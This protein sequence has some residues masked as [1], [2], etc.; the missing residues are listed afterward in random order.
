L[1]CG[2]PSAFSESQQ[3]PHRCDPIFLIYKSS[4]V[5]QYFSSFENLNTPT[6]RKGKYLPFQI[7]LNKKRKETKFM[8]EQAT[9]TE[10]MAMPKHGTFCWNELST[11]NLETCKTFYSELLGWKL[12]R[13]KVTG[14]EMEYIEFGTEDDRKLGGMYQMGKEF[15]NVEGELPPPHWMSYIAVDDVDA[16]AARVW[17]LGGKVCVPPTDIPNVGRFCVVSDPTGATFSLIT[18]KAA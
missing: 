12:E 8:S 9:A 14:E 11:N 2:K 17:E 1:G 6:N 10:Q 16:S 3:I 18:L 13:S 15:C 5:F 4:K 7:F